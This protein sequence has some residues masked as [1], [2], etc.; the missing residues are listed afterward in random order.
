MVKRLRIAASIFLASLSCVLFPALAFA[1]TD[2]FNPPT[3]ADDGYA[4]TSTTEQAFSTKRSD[5]MTATLNTTLDASATFTSQDTTDTFRI[6]IRSKYCFD[7][8]TIGAGEDIDSGSFSVVGTDAGDAAHDYGGS[9]VLDHPSNTSL[10][11]GDFALANWDGVDQATARIAFSAWNGSGGRNSY[12]LNGTAL[13]NINRTGRTCFGLRP[14]WDIDNSAPSWVASYRDSAIN[15]FE[16]A[17]SNKPELVITHHTHV[18]SS[19]SSAASSTP[20]SC[21]G[22]GCALNSTGSLIL[23]HN[24]CNIFITNASGAS[25]GCSQWDTSIEI[26]AIKAFQSQAAYLS[27]GL[28]QQVIQWLFVGIMCLVLAKWF[29]GIITLRRPRVYRMYRR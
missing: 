4:S 27:F 10:G 16:D 14:S 21:S 11:S 28:V 17:G 26:P 15:Y 6:I 1:T 5:T 18:S 7:T 20:P 9:V 22:S 13:G 3:N 2:T 23:Y 19:S 29:F 12:T 24:A 25:V 8:S